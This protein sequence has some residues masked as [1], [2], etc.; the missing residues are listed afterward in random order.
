MYMKQEKLFILLHF[1]VVLCLL[2]WEY[3]TVSERS[4]DVRKQASYRTGSGLLQLEDQDY[5]QKASFSARSTTIKTTTSLPRWPAESAT[6]TSKEMYNMNS[7]GACLQVLVNGTSHT[8]A[9]IFALSY[10]TST[11]I[12]SCSLLRYKQEIFPSPQRATNL[13]IYIKEK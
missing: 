3:D 8:E 10:L 1:F 4:Q 11:N 7:R 6:R 9:V 12:V 13:S 2:N 5:T